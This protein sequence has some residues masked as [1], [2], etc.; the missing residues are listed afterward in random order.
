MNFLSAEN[1]SKS[2]GDRR[3]FEDVTFGVEQGQKIGLIGLN[4]SGKSTLMRVLAGLEP[5]DTGEVGTRK[6]LRIQFLTQDPP[7]DPELTVVETL[8]A[9]DNPVLKAVR[10]YETLINNPSADAGAL[11]TSLEE[12]DR[13]KAWDY[14]AQIKVILGKLGI[15]EMDQLVAELSGGQKKRV[16][17]ARVLIDEP[18]LLFLDEPTN[19]LDLDSIEWLEEYLSRSKL[20]LIMVTHD[21][22]FL[23]RVTNEIIELDR[24]KIQRYRGNYEYYITRKEELET[25]EMASTEK[26]QQLYKKELDWARRQP[27][28]RTTK[29]KAR[30]DQVEILKSAAQNKL[31]REEM[32][33]NIK[34]EYQG[35]TIL[36]LHRITKAFGETKILN[37]FS[38]VFKKGEKLGITGPNGVGKTTFLDMITGDQE[39]DGGKIK[40]G[41]NTIFGFYRQSGL[42]F[43]EDQKVIDV[44]KDVA[45][46]IQLE[47]GRVLTASQILTLFMF[48][49]S[50]QQERVEKLSG[51]EKK[52]LALL[53]V[54]IKNPNFLILDEPTNDLDIPTINTLEAFLQRFSG[55]LLIV[56][57]DRYFMDNLIDHLLVF[58]GE[59]EV[60]DFP[61]NYSQYRTWKEEEDRREMEKTKE[62]KAVKKEILKSETKEK[63]K[64]SFN[65]RR[66]Y[67]QL[68]PII[69]ALEA[70]KAQ[71]AE[72]LS[73]GQGSYEE[74]TAW[75]KELE[76]VKDDLDEKELRWLE[77]AELVD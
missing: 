61:G 63:T 54:L 64:L 11:Q 68:G 4:G 44:V 28:A 39:P 12:M 29:S 9:T 53:R 41:E 31:R 66:E 16:A 10:K 1:L 23:D 30:M 13:L 59:G 37:S 51:G 38:Y 73:S 43:Q 2:Y 27:K 56:S 50:R 70:Q 62:E 6:G 15:S 26:A 17:L 18:D 74:I 67:E 24:C 32:E 36:E 35:K 19:H 42:D 7:L 8:F 49:P 20:S 77:L 57:H 72:K 3:L 22:Y 21:R 33:L 60:K 45:E 55:C 58:K 5:P 75:A 14:E 47:K 76:K 71:I 65:E 25:A 46:N 69:K 52:R 48:S 34:T 40:W